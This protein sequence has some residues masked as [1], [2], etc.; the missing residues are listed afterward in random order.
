MAQHYTEEELEFIK[1]I[2][3]VNPSLS[4]YMGTYQHIV[5]NESTEEVA[6][7]L[8]KKGLLSASPLRFVYVVLNF[9]IRECFR[10]RN[11]KESKK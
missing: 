6:D 2:P 1:A 3:M 10:I 4:E 8:T 5:V 7:A 11:E 9:G